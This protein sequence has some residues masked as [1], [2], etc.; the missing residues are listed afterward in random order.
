MFKQRGLVMQTQANTSLKEK[1]RQERE[2]LILQAAEEVFLEKGYYEASME[3]IAT[4]V[5]I[6]KGTVYLHFPGKEELVAAILSRNLESFIQGIDAVLAPQPTA[7][8]KLEAL[9]EY[10]YSGLFN[11]QTQL[12]SSIYNG[13]DIK[14]LFAEKSGCMR[15]HWQSLTHHVSQLLDEGKAAGE[16]DNSIPTSAMVVAFLRLFSPRNYEPLLMQNMLPRKELI[17]WLDKLYFKGIA[18]SPSPQA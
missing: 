10:M 16:F 4:R 3:E 15:E 5:G 7:K 1:Q 9:L 11:T 13:V 6:A 2:K 17:Q 18:A 8:A 14:R 12:I